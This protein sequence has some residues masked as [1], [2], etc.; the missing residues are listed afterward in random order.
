MNVEKTAGLPALRASCLAVRSTPAVVGAAP[1]P[2][3]NANRFSIVDLHSSVFGRLSRWA[4]SMRRA[5]VSARV[6]IYSCR[7]KG[8][9]LG[10]F[11]A[12]IFR[13]SLEIVPG[14]RVRI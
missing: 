13:A 2:T 12:K 9:K 10:N 14:K 11:D 8:L 4:G 3:R 1:S 6:D 5:A 7:S